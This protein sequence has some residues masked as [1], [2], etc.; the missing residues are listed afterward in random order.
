M[1]EQQIRDTFFAP[2]DQPP[3]QEPEWC[4]LSEGRLIQLVGKYQPHGIN[5]HINLDLIMTYMK[6]IYAKEDAVNLFIRDCDIEA[7]VAQLELPVDE[8]E[9]RF[10]PAYIIR[11]SI[12][13]IKEKIITYW[14]IPALECTTQLPTQLTEKCE[15]ELPSSYF[16]EIQ[17][18]DS[19]DEQRAET[20]HCRYSSNQLENLDAPQRQKKRSTATR[21]EN[22]ERACCRP[23][24]KHRRSNSRNRQCQQSKEDSGSRGSSKSSVRSKTSDL[25]VLPGKKSPCKK[26]LDSSD[27]TASPTKTVAD[28]HRHQSGSHHSLKNASSCDPKS[29]RTASE[30]T[31]QPPIKNDGTPRRPSV[32]SSRPPTAEIKSKPITEF[33]EKMKKSDVTRA[34]DGAVHQSTPKKRGDN[35]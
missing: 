10:E 16:D 21:R 30:S 34:G 15:F 2:L 11:P 17:D 27:S 8:R 33:F 3:R 18:L 26:S 25:K 12:E 20:M 5:K 9:A 31:K 23:S 28:R 13:Q 1:T 6:H 29:R 19:Y 24:T 22:K 14:N 4:T 7:Y 32:R 35:L